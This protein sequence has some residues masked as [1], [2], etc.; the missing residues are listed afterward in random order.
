MTVLDVL[1]D[2]YCT[3]PDRILSVRNAKPETTAR[4]MFFWYLHV[5]DGRT[6]RSISE[7][8][9]WSEGTVRYGVNLV[10]ARCRSMPSFAAECKLLVRLQMKE[11][12]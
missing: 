7:A 6:I 11:A 1:A 2:L 8:F 9:D 5:W 10:K 3:T 12:S 4:Q